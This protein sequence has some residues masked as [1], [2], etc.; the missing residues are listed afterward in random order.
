MLSSFVAIPVYLNIAE[1]L[2][3]ELW[4]TKISCFAS[5]VYAVNFRFCITSMIDVLLLINF[6]IC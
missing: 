3:K 4:N 5:A 2:D 6:Y 1:S